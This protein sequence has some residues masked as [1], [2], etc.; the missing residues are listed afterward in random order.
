LPR[1]AIYCALLFAALCN[2]AVADVARKERREI[3]TS[4]YDQYF[5]KYA[6]HHFGIG[7]DWTWFKA[8]AIAE[9]NLKPNAQSGVRAR[10]LMQLMPATYAELQKKNPELGEISEPRWNI[11]AGIFYD[12]QIWNRLQDV[13]AEAERRRFMFGAYNAGPT[14]INRARRVARDA[15]HAAHEWQGVVS[16]AP[17]V[18]QWRHRET[19]GYISRI[20]TV[21]TALPAQ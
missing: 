1:S 16:V 6:K 3:Y 12:R 9:S 14:T 17:Q 15:G 18:P 7:T 2:Q 20:E 4:E 8:Q 13:D 21:K 19:L 10:G 5:R 11:A